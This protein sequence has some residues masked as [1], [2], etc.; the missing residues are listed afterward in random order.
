MISLSIF[1]LFKDIPNASH[2]DGTLVYGKSVATTFPKR[3]RASH[4]R[5]CGMLRR[6]WCNWWWNLLQ[7]DHQVH[8]PWGC[9]LEVS[10]LLQFHASSSLNMTSLLTTN[11]LISCVIPE[12]FEAEFFPLKYNPTTSE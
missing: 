5:G 12:G 11:F 1:C 7:G 2:F 6:W 4:K 9:S 8:P 3:W 10:S